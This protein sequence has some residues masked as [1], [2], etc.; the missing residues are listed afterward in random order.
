MG[1]KLIKEIH[2]KTDSMF[3]TLDKKDFEQYFLQYF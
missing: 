3:L 2:A 1:N